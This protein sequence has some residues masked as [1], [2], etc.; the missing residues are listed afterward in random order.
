MKHELMKRTLRDEIYDDIS[1]YIYDRNHH[2]FYKPDP[3]S[4]MILKANYFEEDSHIHS[5]LKRFLGVKSL[6]WMNFRIDASK[7]EHTETINTEL[8]S[9]DRL[10]EKQYEGKRGF[11]YSFQLAPIVSKER[12]HEPIKDG[13]SLIHRVEEESGAVYRSLTLTWMPENFNSFEK[14]RERLNEL[15]DKIFENVLEYTPTGRRELFLQMAI[16]D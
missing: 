14:D 8:I 4:P 5:K 7:R 15:L 13:C 10:K 2:Y 12:M 1:K 11:I 3:T 6:K 16:L 9:L